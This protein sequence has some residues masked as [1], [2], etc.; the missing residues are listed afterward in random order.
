MFSSSFFWV[1]VDEFDE[2]EEDEE[3]V[4]VR[5]AM[6]AAPDWLLLLATALLVDEVVDEMDEPVD[7]VDCDGENDEDDSV[8]GALL[9]AVIR[10]E[11][12]LLDDC[13]LLDDNG[14]RFGCILFYYRNEKFWLGSFTALFVVVRFNKRLLFQVFVIA[15]FC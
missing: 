3:V 11:T 10:L 15:L 5:L 6:P 4:D 7:S 1:D 8:L 13:V 2:E 14:A 12:L 9:L